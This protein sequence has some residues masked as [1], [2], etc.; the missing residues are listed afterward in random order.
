MTILQC[1][2]EDGA[3]VDSFTFN[4]DEMHELNLK[5]KELCREI[6]NGNLSHV[7]VIED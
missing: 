1:Y 5:Q 2:D 3:L 4:D 6:N 7:E